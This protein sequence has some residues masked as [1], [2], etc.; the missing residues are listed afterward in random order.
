MTKEKLLEFIAKR[1]TARIS[2][3]DEGGFKTEIIKLVR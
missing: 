1:K 3:V 2:S